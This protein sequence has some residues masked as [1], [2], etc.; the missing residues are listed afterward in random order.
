MAVSCA[1]RLL[2]KVILF[3]RMNPCI[4]NTVTLKLRRERFIQ[5]LKVYFVC[6]EMNVVVL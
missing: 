1:Q 6:W 5:V 2:D 4:I 3:T